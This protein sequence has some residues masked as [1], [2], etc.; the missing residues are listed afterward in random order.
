MA[1]GP[2]DGLA[3]RLRARQLV[4]DPG[5][6][7]GPPGPDAGLGVLPAPPVRPAAENFQGTV[8]DLTGQP[9]AIML[10]DRERERYHRRGVLVCQLCGELG[11]HLRRGIFVAQPVFEGLTVGGAN[12]AGRVIRPQSRPPGT[13]KRQSWF[14]LPRTATTF[15]EGSI[16][17]QRQNRRDRTSRSGPAQ[18]TT[19]AT[20]SA[21]LSAAR[22]ALSM[23]LPSL[24]A[25]LSREAVLDRPRTCPARTICWRS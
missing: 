4:P 12:A 16:R 14:Q 15:P 11:Q 21:H 6:D 2:P 19:L 10:A 22:R 7:R 17:E 3:G 13:H 9:A 8:A 23:A 1:R 25:M 20:S 18:A 5:Q 24:S